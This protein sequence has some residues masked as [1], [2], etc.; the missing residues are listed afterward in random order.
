MKFSIAAAVTIVMLLSAPCTAQTGIE[1]EIKT[2]GYLNGR[3]IMKFMSC[4]ENGMCYATQFITGA[5]EGMAAINGGVTI[6]SIY[7][8]CRKA[9]IIKAVIE[10]YINNPSK[11]HRPVV[12]V[13]LSGCK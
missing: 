7:P 13:I 4:G 3:G 6:K 12:D 11:R 2:K 9:D 5:L 8:D 1:E 10:Y